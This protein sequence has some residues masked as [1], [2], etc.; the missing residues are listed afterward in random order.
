MGFG[1]R[2]PLHVSV[3]VVV[4]FL[5]VAATT[6]RIRRE[7]WVVEVRRL[8]NARL[9]AARPEPRADRPILVLDEANELAA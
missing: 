3:L 2:L 1:T 4:A 6:A 5:T 9:I 7:P 8:T